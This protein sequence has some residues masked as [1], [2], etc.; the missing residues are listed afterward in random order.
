MV[1]GLAYHWLTVYP[2]N[3]TNMFYLCSTFDI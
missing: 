3:D 2:Y 1:I